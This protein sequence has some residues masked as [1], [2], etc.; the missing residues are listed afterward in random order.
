[1]HPIKR[2]FLIALFGFGTVAGFAHGFAHLGWWAHACHADRR[3]AFEDRVADVCTRSAERV[4]D[5]RAAV[6]A[7]APAAAPLPPPAFYGYPP[8]PAPFA[9]PHGP[10][11]GHGHHC[12]H[13][14]VE[15][16][17]D[18]SGPEAPGAP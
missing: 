6:P 1:M 11:H 9:G 16:P 10:R 7:A 2:F 14:G 8:P 5:E 17:S 18:G 12:D 3:A 13:D 15:A 4:W